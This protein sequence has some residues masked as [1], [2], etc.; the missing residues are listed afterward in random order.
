MGPGNQNW[1]SVASSA[2]GAV[3]AGAVDGSGNIWVSTDYGANWV[4][5]AT[6]NNWYSVACSSDG[7]KMVAAVKGGSIWTSTDYGLSWTEQ[8][9]TNGHEWYAVASSA[10]GDVSKRLGA[11]HFVAWSGKALL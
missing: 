6:A 3:L 2:D 10:D 11:F 8:L 5:R 9:S 1:F 7:S 4:Q